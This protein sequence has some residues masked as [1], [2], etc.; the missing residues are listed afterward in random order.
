MRVL[1]VDTNQPP[2][3][4]PCARNAPAHAQCGMRNA[5]CGMQNACGLTPAEIDLV[6]KTARPAWPSRRLRTHS[7]R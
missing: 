3:S 6:W 4:T 1:T 7:P 2:A 5:E